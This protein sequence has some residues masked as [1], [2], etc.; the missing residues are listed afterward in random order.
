[1][2][3]IFNLKENDFVM[4]F[5][6]DCW[7]KIVKSELAPEKVGI[8]R[9]IRLWFEDGESGCYCGDGEVSG[10][11]AKKYYH[12]IVAYRKHPREGQIYKRLN[13]VILLVTDTTPR[14]EEIVVRD[15]KE[16]L[17]SMYS[18]ITSTG[19]TSTIAD[20]VLYGLDF[21]A[22]YPTWQ[23]AVNSEYFKND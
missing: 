16:V 3:P 23:E 21:I 8:A 17:E 6:Q 20:N 2:M 11:T 12:D 10:A 14:V 4:L 9:T 18:Y 22:E 13:G 5:G 1:M 19:Y 7:R 15:Q